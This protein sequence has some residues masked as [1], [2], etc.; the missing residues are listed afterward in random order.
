MVN[1]STLSARTAA[2]PGFI[3]LDVFSGFFADTVLV[4]PHHADAE[5]VKDIVPGVQIFS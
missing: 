4:G 2:H 3:G 1:T 5:L